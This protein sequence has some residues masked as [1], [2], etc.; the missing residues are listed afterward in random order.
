MGG[1]GSPATPDDCTLTT[2]LLGG[3]YCSMEM[4]CGSDTVLISCQED[5]SDWRCG[6]V[7][8]DV[9][10]DY[11][12]FPDLTGIR[13][14][15]VSAVACMHP[16][17]LDAEEVCTLTDD[18]TSSS[19][20]TATDTCASAHQVEGVTLETRSK[21]TASCENCGTHD[22][23]CCHCVEDGFPNYTL[24]A[25]DI[26]DGCLYLDELC[27]G[28]GE[29]TPLGGD[30]CTTFTEQAMPGEF[31]GVG[32]ACEFPSEL[33]DGTELTLAGTLQTSCYPI[34]DTSLGDVT[35]C[36]CSDGDYRFVLN[37]AYDPP[38]LF[39]ANCIDTNRACAGLVSIEPSGAENCSDYT[40]EN[41]DMDRY[42]S[43]QRRCFQPGTLLG[44]EVTTVTGTDVS[45]SRR[46][47][48]SWSCYC[49]D[50]AWNQESVRIELDASTGSE[51][52]CAE[53]IEV[54]PM[55]SKATF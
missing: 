12:Y 6:C 9:R 52:A 43:R 28:S 10:P 27:R 21:W 32:M 26:S 5:G 38:G 50:Q 23:A 31:C 13:A 34:P 8:G 4:T 41:S 54:C 18:A 25:S 51:A 49:Q 42:C 16:E 48:D 15:E 2:H 14:C 30:S 29:I 19:S 3:L 7:R 17:L 36:T 33:A 24:V 11:Y 53:A 45:C 46:D 44:T 47:D 39:L 35:L 55:V 22:H 1:A 37:V 20:C 40:V